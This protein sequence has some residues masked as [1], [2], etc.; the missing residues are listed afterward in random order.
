MLQGT[1]SVNLYAQTHAMAIIMDD[2]VTEDRVEGRDP[3]VLPTWV[4][5]QFRSAAKTGFI[6]IFK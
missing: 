3:S 5:A 1:S 2:I 4:R 6:N